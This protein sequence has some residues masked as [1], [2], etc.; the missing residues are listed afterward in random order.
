MHSKSFL[1]SILVVLI[2][3]GDGAELLPEATGP[4]LAPAA[5][6]A[7]AAAAPAP[8]AQPDAAAPDPGG[9]EK[10]CEC[11]RCCKP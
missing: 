8:A 4:A 2:G 9:T 1:L 11:Q 10:P 3:C 5:A 7:A 6:A